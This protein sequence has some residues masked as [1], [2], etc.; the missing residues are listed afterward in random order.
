MIFIVMLAFFAQY[1][2]IT[3]DLRELSSIWKEITTAINILMA[4]AVVVGA[5]VVVVVGS[6]MIK[7]IMCGGII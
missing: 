5:A 4:K 3:L 7:N 6:E 2:Y 1:I